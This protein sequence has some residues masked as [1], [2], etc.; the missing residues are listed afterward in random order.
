LLDGSFKRSNTSNKIASYKRSLVSFSQ[1]DKENKQNQLSERR[2]GCGTLGLAEVLIRLRL[3]IG[4][5][6]ATAFVNKL[7]E[8][9]ANTAYLTSVDLAKEKGSFDKLDIDKFLESGFMKE[10]SEEV[11]TAVKENGIRNVTLTTQ[12]PTGT[13]GSMLGTS[14][15]IEPFYA[16]K[17]FQQSRLGF[18]EVEIDLVKEYA[19]KEDGSLQDFFVSSM[20]MGPEDHI[21]LQA[22]IQKWTDSSISK[23]ANVPADFT[24]EQTMKLYEYAFDTGCKGVTIYR[25][26]SRDEQILST[27]KSAEDKNSKTKPSISKVETPKAEIP[28]AETKEAD[29]TK[30]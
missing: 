3:R 19:K 23:T 11:R 12:A 25:D 6:D 4:N 7:Y 8:L 15:G 22:T 1:I 17:Y 9:I 5:K 10:M 2:V 13:V 16:F 27:S 20:E 24:V 28:K 26:G 14:T 30:E 21:D 29:K 18:H